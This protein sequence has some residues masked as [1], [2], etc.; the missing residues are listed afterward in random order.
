MRADRLHLPA[1]TS[2]GGDHVQ[3][4]DHRC[5]GC[6]CLPGGGGPGPGLQ[7]LSRRLHDVATRARCAT[8]TSPPSR[9]VYT[10]W[11][12]TKHAEADADNQRP[13]SRTA[14]CCAGCHT[15]NWD[16]IKVVPTPRHR[17]QSS[18]GLVR[19]QAPT[20]SRLTPRHAGGAAS[21]RT[22]SAAPC[23]TTA[24]AWPVRRRPH[25]YGAHAPSGEP[26]QRRHLRS[27]PFAV[28]LHRG[29][30]HRAPRSRTPR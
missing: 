7:R 30:V 26:G 3:T 10:E 18:T 13:S 24:R 29:H 28:L 17:H 9:T 16:P 15:S 1:T 19:G 4:R 14:R 21:L 2:Q 11:A 6:G 22:T 20:A 23:A 12:E 5:A 27:V 25:G 8:P